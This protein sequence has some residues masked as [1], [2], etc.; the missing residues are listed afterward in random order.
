MSTNLI[1]DA[2]LICGVAVVAVTVF[3]KRTEDIPK[4]LPSTE[5]VAP[6]VQTAPATQAP[7]ATANTLT[8][9]RARGQFWS[10][11][12]VNGRPIEFLIDTGASVV[13]LDLASAEAA[14]FS[15]WDLDYRATVSTANG[16]T[17]AAPVVLEV[18]EL[19]PIVLRNVEAIVI[20]TGLEHPLLGMSFLG[21]LQ[22]FS[23]TPDTLTLTL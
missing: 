21:R 4:N 5:A 14:G 9:H 12:H 8:L 6:P 20:E 16:T 15:R 19:G 1:R 7:V 18:V 3:S 17:R 13:A 22:G 2:A 23:A 11:A 10:P